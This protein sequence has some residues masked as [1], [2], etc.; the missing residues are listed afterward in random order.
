MSTPHVY[1]DEPDIPEGMTCR[2]FRAARL[3]AAPPPR[4][5]WSR[6][7]LVRLRARRRARSAA[8]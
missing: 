7:P 1:E 2:E 3:A 4:R 6:L 5:R 8:R